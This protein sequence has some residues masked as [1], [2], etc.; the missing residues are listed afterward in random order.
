MAGCQEFESEDDDNVMK[1]RKTH[2]ERNTE[3]RK[4]ERTYEAIATA[5]E[6]GAHRARAQ[7]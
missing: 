5:H 1:K 2:R 6:A 7:G 4:K 3:K